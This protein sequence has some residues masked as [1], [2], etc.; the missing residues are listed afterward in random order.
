MDEE[1]FKSLRESAPRLFRDGEPSLGVE[2]P[3]GWNHILRTLIECLELQLAALPKARWY[4]VMQVKEKFGALRVYLTE[5]AGDE[6]HGC[7]EFAE[8][9]S[10][11]TCQE[12]GCPAA[13]R[14]KHGWIST[15]CD[16]HWA[17][18]TTSDR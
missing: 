8:R 5:A 14:S 9:L 16:E 15:L 12:C 4:S 10:Q 7:I 2:L 17:Q 3:P 13:R 11:R 1:E 18:R 6:A